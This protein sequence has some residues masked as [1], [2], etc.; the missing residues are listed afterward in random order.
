MREGGGKLSWKVVGCRIFQKNS[1]EGESFPKKKKGLFF[2][3]ER[4]VGK[5]NKI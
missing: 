5:E 3:W 4:K 2:E 1:R